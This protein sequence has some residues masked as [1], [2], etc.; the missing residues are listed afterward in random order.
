MKTRSHWPSSN[1]ARELK[2]NDETIET[3][4]TK[5]WIVTFEVNHVGFLITGIPKKRTYVQLAYKNQ[6]RRLR[7]K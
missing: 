3:E 7:P 5:A 6:F 1:G 2:T 4:M